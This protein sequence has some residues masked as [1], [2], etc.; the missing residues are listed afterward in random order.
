MVGLA[1]GKAA[2]EFP[3]E[4]EETPSGSRI[5][6]GHLRALWHGGKNK[7]PSDLC[8]RLPAGRARAGAPT[9]HSCKPSQ[10]R[11]G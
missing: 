3:S 1:R 10:D 11:A 2:A 8:S 5:Y 9:M 4:L 6:R 7:A